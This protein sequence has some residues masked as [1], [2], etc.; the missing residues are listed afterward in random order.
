MAFA[1]PLSGV[2]AKC[3]FC[4]RPAAFSVVN[5]HAFL[6]KAVLLVPYWDHR[7]VFVPVERSAYQLGS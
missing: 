7:W 3:V 4:I 2:I 1:Q 5:V 6:S